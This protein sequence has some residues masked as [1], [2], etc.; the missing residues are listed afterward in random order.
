MYNFL[1][2]FRGYNQVRMHPKDQEKTTFVTDW[3]VYVAVVMMFVLKTTPMTFQRIIIEIFGEYIP[4][5]MQ[6]FLDDFAVYMIAVEH[7][8]NLRLCL[9]RCQASRLISLNPAK[10]AFNITSGALLGQI[11]SKEGIAVDPNKISAITQA[12]TPTNAKEHSRFLGQIH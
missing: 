7:F 4:A 11:V 1:E 10:C 6:V 5:F 2:G 12:K 8:W 9:E 3:G